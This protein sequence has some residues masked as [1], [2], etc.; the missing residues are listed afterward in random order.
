[1]ALMGMITGLATVGAWL[2]LAPQA[3]PSAERIYGTV[4]T[5]AGER[6][7]GFLRWDRNETHW[8][9]HLDGR[10]TIAPEHAREAERLDDELRRRR[11]LERSVSLPGLRITWDED[12]DA[13]AEQTASGIRFGHVRSLEPRDRRALVTLVSGEEVELFASSSDLGRGFRGLVVERAGAEEV[14][15]EWEDIVRVDLEPARPGPEARSERLHGTLRTRGGGAWTGFVAWSLDESLTTD[16]LDGEHRDGE[17]IRIAFADVASI[18][19]VSRSS[20]RVRLL[21]GVETV[22]E[23]TNDVGDDI[24]GIEITDPSLGRVV[25]EWDDF[26]S[27]ELHPRAQQPLDKTAFD[28]GARL[29]GTVVARDGRRVSGLVRWD[30]DEEHTWEMLDVESEGVMLAIELGRVRSVERLGES[31][32]VTLRDG[33]LL[34][35]AGN[36]ELED[37]GASNRGIFVT[38]PDG[39]T[40][41]VR[42]RDLES[43][44]FEP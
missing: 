27:L 19:R 9:D 6:L 20:A 10:I 22:L 23:D 13:P 2:M 43:A 26:S 24:P 33:R 41:L 18:A 31:A 7:E 15:L 17:R 12:D 5:V 37:V 38:T 11:E 28:G 34:E 16:T 21:T 36:D 32:R 40:V 3:S 39:E 35:A 29:S 44:T 1:M 8:A 30:N 4:S 42:W 25:V 14:E